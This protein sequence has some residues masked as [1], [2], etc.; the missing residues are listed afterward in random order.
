MLIILKLFLI[1]SVNIGRY[2]IGEVSIF[3][4]EYLILF[5]SLEIYDCLV[6]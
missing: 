4:K 2:F 5:I 1:G 6:V 3:M